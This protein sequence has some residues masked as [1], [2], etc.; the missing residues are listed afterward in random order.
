M[1]KKHID[2][3]VNELLG[4]HLSIRERIFSMLM[5]VGFIICI[6]GMIRL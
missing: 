4:R 5:I 1:K 6:A 2:T 3:L